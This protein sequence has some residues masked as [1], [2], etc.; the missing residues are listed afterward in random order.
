MNCEAFTAT[1]HVQDKI[2]STL[3]GSDH[4]NE[5]T[6]A[7]VMHRSNIGPIKSNVVPCICINSNWL[8]TL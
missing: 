2:N 5:V 7:F 1:A 8:F 3:A 4:T 6:H